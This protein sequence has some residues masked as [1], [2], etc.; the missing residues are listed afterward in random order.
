MHETENSPTYT[1]L[2][3]SAPGTGWVHVKIRF[4]LK[5]G[6]SKAYVDGRLHSEA[7][8]DLQGAENANLR[9]A[10]NVE[11]DGSW[12]AIRPSG[13]EPKCKF[14]YCVVAEDRSKAAE[15]LEAIKSVF[16]RF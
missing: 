11:T 12:V 13:T 14:Y 16:E 15:K 5:N 10:C 2:S 9:I 8:I 6:I 4:D 3:T 7:K 1:K